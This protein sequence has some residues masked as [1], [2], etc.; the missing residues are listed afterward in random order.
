MPLAKKSVQTCG[1]QL[2]ARPRVRRIAKTI[3][4]FMD[5]IPRCPNFGPKILA[6]Q[7]TFLVF[8]WT[9]SG[10]TYW[11][12]AYGEF[13]RIRG[14][15]DRIAHLEG[16]LLEEALADATLGGLIPIHAGAFF[17]PKVQRVR[18]RQGADSHQLMAVLGGSG[19]VDVGGK[20]QPLRAGMFALLPAA[21][22]HAFQSETQDPWT[23]L[24]VH[25]TGPVAD[26]W[27][28]RL[29]SRPGHAVYTPHAN[30]GR[31]IVQ[32]LRQCEQQFRL[33]GMAGLPLAAVELRRALV[34]LEQAL[35]PA[36]RSPFEAVFNLFAKSL[37]QSLTVAAMAKAAGLPPDLFNRRFRAQYGMGPKRYFL[38]LK[39][40]KANELL[41]LGLRVSEVARELG[42]DDALYFSRAYRRRYGQPPKLARQQPE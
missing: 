34:L 23:T 1:V 13:E 17:K 2:K 14:P 36:R 27:L 3:F 40:S 42:Y 7:W 8:T 26:A 9:I 21:T 4:V 41:H 20:Q 18:Y 25:F 19:W 39:L 38:R 31:R 22:V 35:S 29:G 24:W 33:P 10:M 5:E 11:N 15:R 30:A 28:D 32:A 12:S 6:P 37:A 16:R